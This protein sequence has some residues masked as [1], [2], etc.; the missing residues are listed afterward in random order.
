MVVTEAVKRRLSAS[1]F[2]LFLFFGA[3]YLFC[4]LFFFLSIGAVSADTVAPERVT[5]DT[6]WRV[7]DG[8]FIISSDLT[9]EFGAKLSVES[10]ATIAVSDNPFIF[11]YGEIVFENRGS[12]KTIVDSTMN[13]LD[14]FPE[15]GLIAF[16][17]ELHTY[18]YGG[19]ASFAN[20]DSKIPFHIQSDGGN[21]L[22]ENSFL[23]RGEITL[24]NRATAVINNSILAESG[25]IMLLGTSS[26]SI[27]DSDITGAVASGSLFNIFRGS[28]VRFEN[29]A[30][31]P[32][33]SDFAL[34]LD[35]SSLFATGTAVSNMNSY[36]I[37]ASRGSN[38]S[39]FD[40]T[41][42]TILSP[43]TSSAF[44]MLVGSTA[45]ITK[46]RFS[47]TESNAME[48][49]QHNG[50]Y[51]KLSLADSTIEDYGGA[52]ISA[53]QANLSVKNSIIHRGAVGIE[54]I[55]A[56]TTV[57]NSNISENSLY[58]ITAYIPAYAV[59]A[60]NNFWGDASGPRHAILN[61]AGLGD[62]VSDNVSFSPWLPADPKISC[63]S[64]VLFLP[65]M[66][67]SRLYEM[68]DQKEN[69]LWEPAIGSN[70]VSKLFM[71][72]AGESIYSDIYTRD[73]ID[74]AIIPGVGSNIYKSFI[75]MMN[76]L[77]K[78]KT[79][80]DW[81]PIP[82]DWRLP[83][84]QIVDSGKKIGNGISYLLATSSPYIIQELKNLAKNSKTGK[85]TLI[86]HSNGGLVAKVLMMKLSEINITSLV[87]K[88]IFVAV[89][90]TGTP[91]AV[92]ALLHGFGQSIP[93]ILSAKTAMEFGLNMPSAYNLLPGASYFDS[94]F[95]PVIKFRE[96]GT[97]IAKST[98]LYDFL[99]E[100]KLNSLLLKNSKTTHESLD[101][102]L[103][104]AN[105]E[106]IQIAG[107]GVDTIS[108][109]EYYQ[110]VK[111]GKP[112]TQYKPI[113][114]LDGDNTVV[115]PSALAISTSTP[116]IQRYW[117][118]LG[119]Y[120]SKEEKIINLRLL[121]RSHADILEV[122]ELRDFIKEIIK[123][124][125]KLPK[126][127]S[128]STP[129]TRDNAKRL[130]FTLHSSSQTIDMYDDRGN[131][132]GLSTTTSS[133][134]EQIPDTY[135]RELGEV[136]YLSAKGSNKAR[137]VITNNAD[138][139]KD[140]IEDSF[141]LDIDEAQNNL[142]A[143]STSFIDVPVKNLTVFTL[144]VPE[145]LSLVPVLKADEN[146]DGSI[147]FYVTPGEF[148]ISTAESAQGP[149][150]SKPNIII[151]SNKSMETEQIKN[152]IVFINPP[153]GSGQNRRTS[154]RDIQE[155]IDTIQLPE[156][157]KAGSEASSSI[158]I[159]ADDK[160]REI[161]SSQTASVFYGKSNSE[162]L[163]YSI[164]SIII[165]ILKKILFWLFHLFA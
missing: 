61:P 86:A 60:E 91:Q 69:R 159:G 110:G 39:L 28:S 48:L 99:A 20:I 78:D 79:I 162:N 7:S 138:K 13:L 154:L 22:V 150:E 89:P 55:F 64:S 147:D 47:N 62:A 34:L 117:F 14:Q 18:I 134:D 53:V 24:A 10:G 71:N 68:E 67:A 93:F 6:T 125:D 30:I 107:W 113:M 52:G 38:V 128:T 114:V 57:S 151:E 97:E 123:G 161:E 133:I 121:N 8:P 40:T 74:E 105:I 51:S 158:Q 12:Q 65:G 73:V 94:V 2:Y 164:L 81:Q 98:L 36:G 109:I 23:S 142:I 31:S 144:D 101:T 145:S 141:T 58:G 26:L 139:S 21:I 15:F 5:S 54:N 35:G 29:S 11:V 127:F 111:R 152:Q 96:N 84:D 153:Y 92:G 56:T 49:Y 137:I 72:N 85:V 46:S 112:V 37:Q 4:L 45:D 108:G 77:K 103:P 63:C 160:V 42:D 129:P 157:A 70:S 50:I 59:S 102:W 44:V 75:A 140:S 27:S 126:Y 76:D 3:V 25:N 122:G 155:L 19:R 43:V 132:T 66:E 33:F 87:D 116:N 1:F 149:E 148:F 165:A 143:S 88:I 9:I 104:P 115:A 32:M 80:T 135:Y 119:K 17:G 156:L 146:S 163:F 16:D 100:K 118:N 41:M 130:H 83:F 136:K 90:Q 106:L 120:N 95:D 82:Y 124:K 131:H